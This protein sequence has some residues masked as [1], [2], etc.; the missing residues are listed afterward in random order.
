MGTF[1]EFYMALLKFVNFKLYSDLGLPYP[2][3]ESDLPVNGEFYK[4]AEMREMQANARK[5]FD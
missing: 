4:S 3:A 5:L 1:N 2:M